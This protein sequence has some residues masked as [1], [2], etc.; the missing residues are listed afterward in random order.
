VPLR[1]NLHGAGPPVPLS[2][3]DRLEE[4]LK[5]TVDRRHI[6][7]CSLWNLSF[8]QT[9]T[10]EDLMRLSTAA[11]FVLMPSLVAVTAQAHIQLDSPLPKYVYN[12]NGIETAP[13][14]SGTLSS[15]VNPPIAGGSQL[16]V[17]WHETIN[18]DGHYR[19]GL[20]ANASDF[21]VPTSLTI[22]SPPLPSWDLADGI[23][24]VGGNSGSYTKTIT[25]PNM[26]CPN[27]ILQVLQ[28][29]SLSSDGSNSGGYYTNYYGCADLAITAST[30]TAG[31]GGSTTGA[32]GTTGAGGT[33]AAGGTTGSGATTGGPGGTTGAGGT[34]GSGATT[35]GLGGTT[36]A[37]NTTGT[38]SGGTPGSGT[39]TAGNGGCSY[40]SGAP[41]T[42]SVLLFAVLLTLLTRRVR[43]R[44]S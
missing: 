10:E 29:A 20:S 9:S 17:K 25:L 1:E 41:A 12:I 43:R 21:T 42:T 5:K 44:R 13:C 32:A 37:G 40:A 6:P 35:G 14:G 31:T 8:S 30:G 28:I 2:L 3:S 19:I 24:D 7:A 38:G 15:T 27:C 33:S 26:N 16:T 34:T 23:P 39:G 22:P 11:A 4:R 18:H 36:G